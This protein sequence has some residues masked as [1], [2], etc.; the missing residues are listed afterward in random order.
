[1]LRIFRRVRVFE[2]AFDWHEFVLGHGRAGCPDNFS[3]KGTAGMKPRRWRFGSLWAIGEEMV[4]S[5]RCVGEF[6][7]VR[8]AADD[9]HQFADQPAETFRQRARFVAPSSREPHPNL[10][11]LRAK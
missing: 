7:A 4:R 9:A 11:Q 1:M 8:E 10:M 6:V 5:F 3:R 2:I